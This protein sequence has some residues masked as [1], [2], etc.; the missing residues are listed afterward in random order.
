MKRL[1][2]EA[3]ENDARLD[4]VLGR[5][6]P[7]MGLRG[8]RRLC[9]LGLALVNGRAAAPARKMREGDIVE[10][11]DEASSESAAG[12]VPTGPDCP[13]TPDA[14]KERAAAEDRL[15]PEDAARLIVRTAHLAALCKPAS[16][17][18]ESLAG[19]PGTSLQ[20]LLPALLGGRKDARLL[21]RL[22]C[23]TSGLTLAALDEEG[24]RTYRDA[25]EEGRTEKRYLALLEGALGRDMLADQ[26]LILKNRSRVLVELAPHPDRRRHTRVHPLAVLDASLLARSLGLTAHGWTGTPPEAVTLAGCTILKGARHQ[27]RAHCSALGH[28]L[29]GD[30]RYGAAFRPGDDGNEAFFL[31]HARFLMPSFDALALPV[32]LDALGEDAARAAVRWLRA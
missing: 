15:F 26:K 28:P 14:L 18:T 11:R 10:L 16:M 8:R 5:L 1:T 29:L 21:N 4:R 19:K 12:A 20:A 17:H 30:R 7:D 22:D 6:L 31:H 24:E 2:V 9:E 25:Q 13:G 3:G 23:P 27:I 32:W